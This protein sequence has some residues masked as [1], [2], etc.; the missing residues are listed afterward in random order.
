MSPLTVALI[1][2][3]RPESIKM[4]PIAEQLGGDA[5]TIHTGQHGSA[6][7]IQ[8]RP[9]QRTLT[10]AFVRRSNERPEIEGLFGCRVE[11]PAL[12]SKLT[13]AVH[14]RH[15]ALHAIPSPYGD[16]TAAARIA[17]AARR[18]GG[19]GLGAGVGDRHALARRWPAMC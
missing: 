4:A 2:G 9:Q 15:R 8:T 11:P 12:L 7:M 13:A 19:G 5:V 16:G 1:V 6:G 14:E 17:D 10:L 3:T 18:L